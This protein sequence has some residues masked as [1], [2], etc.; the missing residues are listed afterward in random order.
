MPAINAAGVEASA[1]ALKPLFGEIGDLKRIRSAGHDSTI[2]TRLFRSAWADLLEGE[3]ADTV[4][5]RMAGNA[6]AATRLGDID[7]EVLESAGIEADAVQDIRRAAVEAVAHAVPRA[8]L[9]PLLQA[10]GM[11]RGRIGTA[12]PDF[13]LK[14]E[15]QPRAGA[16][17]PG[18]PRVVLEPAENH[19]EHCA[20]VAVYGV[21]LSSHYGADP[22]TVCLAALAHHLHS[23]DLPDSGFTGEV[24]LGDHLATVIASFTERALAE[25]PPRLQQQT[26]AARAILVDAATPE[27]RAFHAADAIDRVLQLSQHLK[28]ASLTM[29]HLMADMALVHDGPVKSFQDRVLA[30]MGLP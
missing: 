2:A 29:T 16:T 7:A 28:V 30:D 21:L 8:S 27:G 22:A 26:R 9:D 24:L 6:L 23:A 1:L 11:G 15:R 17:C 12:V 19:A 13:V 25:L 10:T 3:P 5:H 4:A 14:L 18:K 20:V